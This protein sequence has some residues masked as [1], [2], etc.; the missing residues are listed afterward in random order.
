M[1]PRAHDPDVLAGGDG[2]P[3]A[4]R[5]VLVVDDS[6]DGADS[7]GMMLQALG[8]EVTVLYDGRAALAHVLDHRPEIV[9]LDIGMPGMSGYEVA[10]EIRRRF[11]DVGHVILIALTGW[12]QEEDRR[13]SAEAGFDHHVVKP[14]QFETLQ[15]VLTSVM[16]RV[17]TTLRQA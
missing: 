1:E 9:L 2:D 3:I 8:A 17:R 5:R 13:R 14:L 15:S 6:Q 11:A 10:R 12:G 7:L 16:T 4:G